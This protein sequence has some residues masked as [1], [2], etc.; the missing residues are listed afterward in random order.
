MIITISIELNAED[1]QLGAQLGAQLAAII[2]S[3][4]SVETD[5]RDK[6]VTRTPKPAPATPG[7]KRR[8]RPPKVF[9]HT[10]DWGG[11]DLLV[12]KEMERLRSGDRM[13]ST[14]AWNNE[15]DVR[16]PTMAGILAAYEAADLL[17]LSVILGLRPP[18]V[19]LGVQPAG[20]VGNG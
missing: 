4:V 15:R 9:D 5:V 20:E 12:R 3:A 1:P 7:R 11:F 16:L 18:M 2:S 14:M 13:P 8:G 19:A 10:A 6:N 17:H